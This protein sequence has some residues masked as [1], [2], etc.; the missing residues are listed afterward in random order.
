M[1]HRV[2][3]LKTQMAVPD[4]AVYPVPFREG[5]EYDVGPNLLESFID[6]GVVEIAPDG[7]PA[8]ADEKSRTHAPANKMKK[9]APENKAR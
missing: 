8:P 1:L 5:E 7:E 2:K 9:A 4:D 6:L 3:M